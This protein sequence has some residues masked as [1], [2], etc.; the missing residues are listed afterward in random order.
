MRPTLWVAILL[1]FLAAA[2]PRAGAA[3][4]GPAGAEP[5][6]ELRIFLMTFSPGPI[7]YER[8]GHNALVIHDPNP[9]AQRV[10]ERQAYEM[11]I[12]GQLQAAPP[13]STTD[14]AHH[15]G[16][17]GFDQEGFVPR[18]IMGRMEYWTESSWAD[19]TA[20][21]YAKDG[22][23]VL[24]QELNLS[25]AQ[26]LELKTFLEWNEKPENRLYRYDY[27]KD[28]CSTRVRDAIDRA[29][30]G[31]LKRQLGAIPTG[32]T[33]RSHTR[34]L[35]SGLNPLDVF[36]FTGFTYVLGRPVD[37]PLSAWEESF[38]PG[39]LAEHL[40]TV[41]LPDGPGGPGGTKP[42]VLVEGAISKA[43]RPP[44]PAVAPTRIVAYGVAGI[45]VGGAFVG[46]AYL[47]LRRRVARIGFS[48]L[49]VPW[50]LV[51]GIGAAVAAYGWAVT[52][53]TASYR[54]ENL[55]QMSPLILPLVILGPAVAYGRRRGARLAMTIGVIG[56]GLSFVGFALQL[57]PSCNQ[58][59]G[60]IIA[61]LLPANFGLAA[62][63]VLMGKR[64]DVLK[65]E[66]ATAPNTKASSPRA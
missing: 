61:L 16:A 42:L 26:K 41:T 40:R 54:N 15:Y 62:A 59:N 46:L 23:Q 6:S 2:V 24:V 60:E 9:P 56:A 27:Y 25:P 55:L 45:L 17:F 3:A 28:N 29:T 20:L 10:A 11:Q 21:V 47:A 58:Q 8:F 1:L 14:R 35:T 33:F 53:H 38:L 51:W 57:L 39:K 22:R 4:P 7:I 66:G 31:E 64:A 48:L 52:D 13:F 44:M 63:L 37:E 36:W 65:V 12:G 34:R 19:L 30:G 49:I 32:T 18:F 50:A 43:T 5:G